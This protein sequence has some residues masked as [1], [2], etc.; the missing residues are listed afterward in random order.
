MSQLSQITL[1]VKPTAVD[2]T[3]DEEYPFVG[4]G[5]LVGGE[6]RAKVTFRLAESAGARIIQELL[7]LSDGS[8]PPETVHGPDLVGVEIR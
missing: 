6:V 5:D 2:R 4:T 3:D 8:R 7:D 1:Q